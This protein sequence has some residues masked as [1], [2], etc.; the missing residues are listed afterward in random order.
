MMYSRLI[1]V[2]A[3]GLLL[4]CGPAD[5]T[6]LLEVTE[7]PKDDSPFKGIHLVADEAEVEL[8][9][10]KKTKV[11]A[12]NGQVP[13]PTIHANL[14]DTVTIKFENKLP[15]PS[16]V[17]WHGME[18]PAGMDGSHISQKT[19]QPG[20]SFIYTFKVLRAATYWY[21][22]HVNN[23]QQIERGLHGALIVHDPKEDERLGLP[24]KELV[25]VLDDV[26]LDKSFQIV[27]KIPKNPLKRME[28]LTNG[29]EGNV[30]LVNGIHLPTYKVK[31]GEPVRLRIVNVANSRFFRLSLPGQVWHQVGN[32]M[33][34]LP[35]PLELKE[36]Q[37]IK[38]PRKPNSIS[39]PD[40]AQGIL[41][42]PG[43]RAEIIWIPDLS[44]TENGMVGLEWHDFPRGR[45]KAHYMP[46]ETVDVMLDAEDGKYPSQVLAQFYVEKGDRSFG[47]Q[48]PFELRAPRMLSLEDVKNL[49]PLTVQ[50]GHGPG[51]RDGNVMFF[52]RTVKMKNGM[53]MGVPMMK[54]TN[55]LALNAKVGETRFIE[56]KNMAMG[57]HSFHMHGFPFELLETEFVDKDNPENNYVIKNDSRDWREQKDTFALPG[58]PGRYRMRSWTVSRFIV[59]FDDKKRAGQLEAHGG[60]FGTTPEMSGGWLVHCH[61]LEHARF[62]MATWLNLWPQ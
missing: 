21:H 7:P 6:T 20:E 54:L 8:V 23:H 41:L 25:M 33:G 13:G 1:A 14:G 53:M 62:G 50:F 44:K 29:R 27:E 51:D 61:I 37:T 52:A 36:V 16:T 46:D 24:K 58:R 10:G 43:E 5:Q 35:E 22:A 59:S 42:T 12:Y 48:I 34:L 3:L 30:L 19:V 18:V 38:D 2:S 47:F 9:P 26:L 28:Y 57:I 60:K 11:W 55:E 15:E 40:P 56:V 45:H 4:A 49:K 32:D 31:D 17:H 39:D